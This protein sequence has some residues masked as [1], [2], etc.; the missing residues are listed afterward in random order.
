MAG[1]NAP[2][3]GWFIAPPDKQLWQ[4]LPEDRQK[5]I[6]T[7]L[8]QMVAKR[9]EATTLSSQEKEGSDE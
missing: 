4:H 9:I 3:S 2:P 1:F 7:T 8:A 6:G 5:T